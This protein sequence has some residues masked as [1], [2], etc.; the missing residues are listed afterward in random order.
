MATIVSQ[1]QAEAVRLTSGYLTAF[2]STELGTRTTGPTLKADAYA[3]KSRT[4]QPLRETMR[5]PVYTV[6]SALKD[7]QDPEAALEAGWQKAKLLIDLDVMTA[8][9]ASLQSGLEA[10]ERFTGWTRAV[11]GTCGACM[12][13][14]DDGHQ[15][16]GTPMHI[17]PN[18]KCVSEP[19]IAVQPV[20]EVITGD[21]V[22]PTLRHLKTA[23]GKTTSDLYSVE[24]IQ[25][26]ESYFGSMFSLTIN[27]W[28]REGFIAHL[29]ISELDAVVADIKKIVAGLDDALAVSGAIGKPVRTYRV[30]TTAPDGLK[31]PADEWVGQGFTDPGFGS[32]SAEFNINPESTSIEWILDIDPRVRAL[33]GANPSES[34]LLLERGCRYIIT[35]TERRGRGRNIFAKVLPPEG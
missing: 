5:A 17:H 25:A 31:G 13:A 2:L 8:A 24:S 4:G 27:Q 32:T 30:M 29:D 22:F 33:Y 14:S 10:D 16:P 1:T 19:S 3:G 15:E 9:R 35:G 12:G 26:A 11:K 6:L 7:G 28:L 20:A 23:A 34:E 18:C 21:R